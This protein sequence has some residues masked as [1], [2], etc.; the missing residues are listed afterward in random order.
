MEYYKNDLQGKWRKRGLD[1][2]T[3]SRVLS[4]ASL[5]S[6]DFHVIKG[7]RINLIYNPSNISG[8]L[9]EFSKRNHILPKIIY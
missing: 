9:M 2:T 7:L 4:E 6:K 1:E 5:E 3:K 8:K